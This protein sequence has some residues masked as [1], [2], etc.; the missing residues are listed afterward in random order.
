[1]LS[2]QQ[3]DGSLR[4]WYIAPDYEYDEQYLLTFYSGEALLALLEY[5]E[6]VGDRALVSQVRMSVDYYVDRYVARLD[7]N[8]YPAYVPWMTLALEKIYAVTREQKYLDAVFTLNDKLLEIQDTT[9][10]IGRFY[11][12]ATP[13]YGT[14]HS[15]SDAV[16]TESLIH[17]WLIAKNAGDTARMTKY[18]AAIVLSLGNLRTLQYRAADPTFGLPFTAYEGAL[19]QNAGSTSVRIDCAQHLVDGLRAYLDNL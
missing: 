18:H 3:A 14:P 10:A 4:A 9:Q 7:K 2:L 15:S 1:M 8:Y 19:R 11:N 5:A 12:P 13:Q 16:Y 6:K 17:A